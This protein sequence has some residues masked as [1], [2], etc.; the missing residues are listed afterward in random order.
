VWGH[1][2]STKAA[3]L[4]LAPRL[5]LLGPEGIPCAPDYVSPKRKLLKALL[6]SKWKIFPSRS[7]Q[8]LAK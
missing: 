5:T 2:T 4:K 8:Q 1:R 3:R 7:E 6:A